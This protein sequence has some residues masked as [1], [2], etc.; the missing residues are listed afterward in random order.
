MEE[1][2]EVVYR[3]VPWDRRLLVRLHK[4][5]AG[6]LFDI[7]CDP[8][9]GLRQ[10]HL[11]H[12]E[13]WSGRDFLSVAHVTR[14]DVEVIAP[15]ET[16]E[17]HVVVDIRGFSGYGNVKDEDS[18]AGLVRALVLL[19]YRPPVDPDQES[20][21]NVLLLPKNVVLREVLRFRKT[22]ARGER[23]LETSPHCKLQPQQDYCLSTSPQDQVLV[24][25]TQ[26]EFDCD[27]DNYFPS[28]QVSWET[29]VRH[30]R[31]VLTEASGSL[32]VWERQVGLWSSG[33]QSVDV[34]PEDR[35]LDIRSGFIDG[36]SGPVLKKLL[37]RLLERTVM[38]DSERETADEMPNKRDK[39][40]FVI[41]TV[42]KKGEA[43]CSEMIHFLREADPFLCEHLGLS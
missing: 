26:A 22:V 35:L 39:A 14:E 32:S 11:P 25:P 20:L 5:P 28:F 29:Q 3:V 38:G 15:R 34:G 23:Y 12:C 30:M 7:S 41:D 19:F 27:Y 37:D 8:R 13:T 40:R 36:V 31:L 16:T 6:P 42:R 10:L 2:G 1:E 4:K 24:Q 33:G 43:A 18:P 9:S 17:T 21:L